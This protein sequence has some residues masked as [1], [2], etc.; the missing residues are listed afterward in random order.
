MNLVTTTLPQLQDTERP[1]VPSVVDVLRDLIV[2]TAGQ[3]V[4]AVPVRY[5][6]KVNVPTNGAPVVTTQWVQRTA[7]VRV[8]DIV[9][10]LERVAPD[11]PVNQLRVVW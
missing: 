4:I 6:D 3:G 2:K 1:V 7:V 11:T 5:L 8:A 9:A 10:Q